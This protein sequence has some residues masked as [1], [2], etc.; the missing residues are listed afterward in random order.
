MNEF[1]RDTLYQ[2]ALTGLNNDIERAKDHKS[3]HHNA[4]QHKDCVWCQKLTP[5]R[6]AEGKE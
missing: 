1:T 4:W 6:Q 3:F 5:N 2:M